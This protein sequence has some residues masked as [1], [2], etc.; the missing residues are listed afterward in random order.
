MRVA[1]H[2]G[3]SERERADDLAGDVLEA[4]ATPQHREE[5]FLVRAT[6]CMESISRNNRQEL[7]R[8][9]ESFSRRRSYEQ[10]KVLENGWFGRHGESAATATP[11]QFD[12]KA[13]ENADSELGA[14]VG[15]LFRFRA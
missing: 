9:I 10:E 7:V 5:S 1:R 4:P 2:G 13:P 6:V 14:E 11:W 15:A 12:R 8:C 3:A